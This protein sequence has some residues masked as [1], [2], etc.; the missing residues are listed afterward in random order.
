MLESVGH[1]FVLEEW[2]KAYPNTQF[3][4]STLSDFIKK[5]FQAV[6]II[7]EI[8][9]IMPPSIK[10]GDNHD[11]I[12]FCQTHR[13]EGVDVYA[14]TQDVSQ[15]AAGV[16]P[17]I[18]SVFYVHNALNL[19]VVTVAEFDFPVTTPATKIKQALNSKVQQYEKKDYKFYRSSV[20]HFAK[21]KIPYKILIWIVIIVSVVGYAITKID[22][23]ML[24]NVSQNISGAKPVS[25]PSVAPKP[26]TYQ[27]SLAHPSTLPPAPVVS[28]PPPPVPASPPVSAPSNSSI[29]GFE[30]D[31]AHANPLTHYGVTSPSQVSFHGYSRIGNGWRWRLCLNLPAGRWCKFFQDLG[32]DFDEDAEMLIWRTWRIPKVSESVVMASNDNSNL[33]QMPAQALGATKHSVVENYEG[34][35]APLSNPTGLK[36]E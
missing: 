5:P 6:V 33:G 24:A 8:Q 31:P 36:K 9:K 16:K 3:S 32:F 20:G 21:A 26:L 1:P 25:Q 18:Q 17:L 34:L 15:L 4:S 2:Q 27:P 19:G 10:G 12:K 28:P 13:Q 30:I 11:Y 35:R 22:V 7:D 14:T 23:N 29:V